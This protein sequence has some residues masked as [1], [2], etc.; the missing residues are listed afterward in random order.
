MSQLF[1]RAIVDIPID[2]LLSFATDLSE[3]VFLLPR[4]SSGM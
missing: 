3:V 2:T 4:I 1:L